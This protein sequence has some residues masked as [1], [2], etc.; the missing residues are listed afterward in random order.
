MLRGKI[1]QI[2]R[3]GPFIFI[4]SDD[5]GLIRKTIGPDYYLVYSEGMS[6]NECSPD[7]I[8]IY[9]LLIKLGLV[10]ISL[11][12]RI[13]SIERMGFAVKIENLSTIEETEQLLDIVNRRVKNCKYLLCKYLSWDNVESGKEYIFAGYRIAPDRYASKKIQ[14]H[15]ELLVMDKKMY[16]CYNE[17]SNEVD[18]FCT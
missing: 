6:N 7:E 10:F 8:A 2:C 11:L 4:H 16:I 13:D 15:G 12:V 5:V 9:R 14:R 18:D 1:G 17:G 3:R